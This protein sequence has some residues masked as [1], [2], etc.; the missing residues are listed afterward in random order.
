MFVI[1]H[2][3]TKGCGY[4]AHANIQVCTPMLIPY[5]MRQDCCPYCMLHPYINDCQTIEL[6]IWFI[7]WHPLQFLLEHHICCSQQGFF[8][9]KILNEKKENKIERSP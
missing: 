5:T 4:W 6:A 1:F 8:S 3:Y 2:K 9:I 7:M